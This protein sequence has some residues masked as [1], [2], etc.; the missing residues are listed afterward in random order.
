MGGAASMPAVRLEVAGRLGAGGA[1]LT[2]GVCVTDS[3]GG[4]GGE[5][6]NGGLN[7]AGDHDSECADG[8]TGPTK[9][10]HAG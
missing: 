9:R 2:S 8:I 6:V 3:A 5:L 10:G 7:A 4:A 1:E